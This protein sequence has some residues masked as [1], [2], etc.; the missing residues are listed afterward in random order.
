VGRIPSGR[1]YSSGPSPSANSVGVARRDLA[2]DSVHRQFFK[3]WLLPWFFVICSCVSPNPQAFLPG[4][5]FFAQFQGCDILPIGKY[6]LGLALVSSFCVVAN[7]QAQDAKPTP[8]ERVEIVILGDLRQT[9][10]EPDLNLNGAATEGVKPGP[11]IADRILQVVP[12]VEKSKAPSPAKASKTSGP[13]SRKATRQQAITRNAMSYRGMPY[14]WGGSQVQ[15]GIDCS[16]FTRYLYLKEGVSLP[17]SAKSQYDMGKSVQRA[18]L[19]AGDLVF[20]GAKG[21]ITH[22]GMY[23]GGD[24]FIHASSPKRGIRVDSLSSQYYQPKYVGARRY[25]A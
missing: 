2:D 13:L 4:P 19:A 18:D 24:K 12:S 17:H 11:P 16:G 7:A 5:M 21:A 22:V 20:F 25:K 14:R 9:L 23:I 10:P 6:L 15:T 1:G 3:P 8:E